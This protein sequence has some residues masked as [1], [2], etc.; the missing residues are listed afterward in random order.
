MIKGPKKQIEPE[1]VIR[2]VKNCPNN[3]DGEEKILLIDADSI[4]YLATYFPEDSEMFFPTEEEQLEEAKFRVRNK[5]QEIQN[6]VEEWF[7]IIQTYIF[8]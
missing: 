6:N 1:I 4:C 2:A 8:I 3:Y 5:L 7:N